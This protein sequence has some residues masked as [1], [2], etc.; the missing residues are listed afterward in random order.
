MEKATI[1]GGG[2]RSVRLGRQELGE[3]LQLPPGGEI[4]WLRYDPEHDVFIGDVQAP[5]W[6]QERSQ[7]GSGYPRVM[8]RRG[9]WQTVL[10]PV[11]L[12]QSFAPGM[13]QD[14]GAVHLPV[15]SYM[16]VYQ[17]GTNQAEHVYKGLLCFVC[18]QARDA[19]NGESPVEDDL[20]TPW[21]APLA[22]PART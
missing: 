13:C 10:L 4:L 11:L 2:I 21:G 14:C 5:A 20:A 18:A 6:D 16:V 15:T 9:Q 1:T 19:H 22:P 8:W 7:Q 17:P 12:A 3:A